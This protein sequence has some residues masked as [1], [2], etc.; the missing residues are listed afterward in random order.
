MQGMNASATPAHEEYY[1]IDI[2]D[3]IIQYQTE[4]RMLFE[5]TVQSL[6]KTI[7]SMFKTCLAAI[8]I[9]QIMQVL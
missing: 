3:T 2:T 7:F 1:R 4:T 5:E 6:E 8:A 9:D